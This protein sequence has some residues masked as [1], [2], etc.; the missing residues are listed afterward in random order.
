MPSLRGPHRGPKPRPPPRGLPAGR[1][2]RGA[3]ARTWL[4]DRHDCGA[5]ERRAVVNLIRIARNG[6]YAR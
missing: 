1:L 6:D 4:L 5:D 3:D 2:H